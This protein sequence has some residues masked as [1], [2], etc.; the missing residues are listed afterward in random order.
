MRSA[1]IKKLTMWQIM[2]LGYEQN[3]T[4]KLLSEKKDEVLSHRSDY[5]FQID[6]QPYDPVHTQIYS[7]SVHHEQYKSSD[8][9]NLQLHSQKERN[10]LSRMMSSIWC[11]YVNIKVSF[12]IDLQS[13]SKLKVHTNPI[14]ICLS[15]I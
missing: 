4:I 13:Q 2:I 5:P 14:L 10:H 9:H 7:N 3:L 8:D 11:D 12:C 6:S 1:G 15:L